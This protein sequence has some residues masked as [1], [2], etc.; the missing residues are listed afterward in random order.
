MIATGTLRV[1]VVAALV[2][3]AVADLAG[4]GGTLSS[5]G[6]RLGVRRMVTPELSPEWRV[7]ER[8][9]MNTNGLSAITVRPVAVGSP[10]G[11]IR[12][13]LRSLT[14]YAAPVSRTVEVPVASLVRSSSYRFSFAPIAD[15]RG[16]AY[17]LDIS[18]SPGAP[19]RGVAFRATRGEGLRNAALL[20]NDRERWADLAFQTESTQ[21]T[22]ATVKAATVLTLL[23]GAWVAFVLLLREIIKGA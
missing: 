13:E 10:A 16:V 5:S 12:L 19:S 23:C 17:Q 21:G 15:S 14:A 9:R 18:S 4:L 22:L 8:F 11:R 1:T 7:S 6:E 20:I 2:F 3:L